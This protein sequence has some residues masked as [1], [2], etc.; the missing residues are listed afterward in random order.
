[1]DGQMTEAVTV[2]DL[3]SGDS[4]VYGVR[5]SGPAVVL[6]HGWSCRRADWEPIAVHLSKDFTIVTVDLPGHGDAAVARAWTVAE[7]GDL[8]AQMVRQLKLGEVVLVGHSMGGAVALEAA[9][10]LADECRQVV[11]VDSLTYLNIYPRQD[12]A[13]FMPGVEA[14]AED[15]S[16]AMVGL[17]EALSG[18]ETSS[19]INSVIASEM[20][21]A[22]PEFAVPLL[23][24]LYRW[25]LDEALSDVEA[26]IAIIASETLLS[27]EAIDRFQSFADV[28]AVD[29]G[30]HFFL[31]EAPGPTAQ[32]LFK[33]IRR[34]A[35]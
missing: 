22:D 11:A 34:S 1:M 28:T 19:Q 32:V 17:V 27:S 23:I 12:D 20:G 21:A 5:G 10:R 9:R 35:P 16:G 2:L 25:D 18:P 29:L 24:D 31:R 6:L 14:M 33:V 26:P 4:I 8:V 13:D 30:G 15:F 7:M 3:E